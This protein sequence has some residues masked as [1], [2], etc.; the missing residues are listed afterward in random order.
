MLI[1]IGVLQ[2]ISNVTTNARKTCSRHR[3]QCV[4]WVLFNIVCYVQE[5]NNRWRSLQQLAEERSNM[6][7]SAH[8][9]QRFHRYTSKVGY[10]LWSSVIE[11]T[12]CFVLFIRETGFGT[13]CQLQQLT[14]VVLCVLRDADETKEWIEEKNQALNTDNYGHDLASVQALQRKHE[15]FERD[16]AALGDKVR[17]TFSNFKPEILYLFFI[18]FPISLLRLTL[19]ERQQSAWSSLTLKRWMT[20]RRNAQSWTLPGAA[21]WDVL[22]S[23]KTSLAIPMTCS[24]SS[25]TS[26]GG[27]TAGSKNV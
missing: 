5:L 23:A 9:V 16:L 3:E 14:W 27:R 26:G 24:V 15:G 7:G 20:S 1:S 12:L 11:F 18:N 21:W 17:F 4:G 22:T 13:F 2:L 19:L 10:R 25:L 8:E 6:L